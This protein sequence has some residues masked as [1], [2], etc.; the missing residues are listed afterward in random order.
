MENINSKYTFNQIDAYSPV[1]SQKFIW[2]A[3]YFDGTGLPE[4]DYNT[5]KENKFK[6][7]DKNRLTYFG[8][9]GN[10]NKLKFSAGNGLFNINGKTFSVTFKDTESDIEY[11]LSGNSICDASDI[12]TFKKAHADMKTKRSNATK[13]YTANTVI[14]AFYFG[15]KNQMAFRDGFKLSYKPIVCI[16]ISGRPYMEINMSGNDN[17]SGQLIIKKNNVIIDVIKTSVIKNIT[18][19]LNWFIK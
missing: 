12:I 7:I 4:I 11:A 18:M 17:K 9:V 14:D 10:G 13:I 6:D 15:Y 3:E 5:K 16:P 1:D 2:L 8:L 19:K